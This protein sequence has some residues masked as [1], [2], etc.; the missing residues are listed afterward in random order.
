MATFDSS[1]NI[2]VDQ[3]AELAKKGTTLS[4]AQEELK[5]QNERDFYSNV[6]SDVDPDKIIVDPDAVDAVV[7]PSL[8]TVVDTKFD[9]NQAITNIDERYKDLQERIDDPRPFL[10]SGFQEGDFQLQKE[11]QNEIIAAKLKYAESKVGAPVNNHNE[12][13]FWISTL[14]QRY[15]TP[16]GKANAFEY[17]YPDGDMMEVPIV[18]TDGKK[19]V[20]TVYKKNQEEDYGLLYPFGRDVNEFG[21]VGAELLS[22][23]TLGASFAFLADPTKNPALAAGVGD[24][25]GIKVDKLINWGIGKAL[26]FE[27]GEGEFSK[28]DKLTDKGLLEWANELMPVQ[29]GADKGF[30]GVGIDED[31]FPAFLTTAFTKG[32]GVTTNMLS[33]ASRPGMVPIS[34]KVIDIAEELDLPPHI[35][36]QLA[37]NPLIHKTF[38]RA[39][40]I[41][42]FGNKKIFPQQA[43]LFSKLKAFGVSMKADTDKITKSINAQ[44]KNGDFGKKGT[45]DAIAE[46]NQALNKALK[47]ASDAQSITWKDWADLI[48]IQTN[49]LSQAMKPYKITDA[50]GK[51]RLITP[52]EGYIGLKQAFEEWDEVIT[53]GIDKTRAGVINNSAGVSYTIGGRDSLKGLINELETGTGAFRGSGASNVGGVGTNKFFNDAGELITTKVA[54][55]L[56]KKSN[57]PLI[58]LV[59][60]IK[61][62]DDVII[63]PKTNT[64]NLGAI[65]GQSSQWDAFSQLEVLRSKAF[66]LMSND[67]AAVREAARK[68]HQ[69]IVNIM[70][71]NTGKFKNGGSKKYNNSMSVHLENLKSYESVVGL[72]DMQTAIGNKISPD[73]FASKYFQPGSSYNLTLLKEALEPDNINWTAFEKSFKASLIRNPKEIKRTIQ[74]WQQKD[75][76]GLSTLLKPNEIDDLLKLSETANAMENSIVQKAFQN[77]SDNTLA[78]TQELV[79]SLLKQ[80]EGKNIG[81]ALV[82]Q[83]FIK[84]SGG[85]DGKVMNNVRSGMIEDILNKSSILDPKTNTLVI[86]PR[87]LMSEFKK[88]GESEHLKMFFTKDQL[89]TLGKFELYT[90]VLGASSDLGGQLAAAELGSEA[91]KSILDPKKGL[92]FLKTYFSYNV[93]AHLLGRDVTPKM[94]QKMIP[95]GFNSSI[96]YTAIRSAFGSIISEYMNNDFEVQREL[97]TGVDV[98]DAVVSGRENYLENF[99]SNLNSPFSKTTSQ[100]EMGQELQRIEEDKN[101]ALESSSLG[102]ANMGFRSISMN[103]GANTAERGKQLFKD[104]IT[105]AAQ[106]G[107]MNTRTAFQRVA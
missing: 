48:T 35:V 27:G 11:R 29:F 30:F 53:K 31:V 38:F 54:V 57:N 100:I 33:G 96:K 23:R 74:A 28:V 59:N 64:P 80:A 78:N 87:L 17:F 43:E 63:N 41:T 44:Y 22:A 21:V 95:N 77:Q 7:T 16:E 45:M 49:K 47:E 32:I 13:G 85:M 37:I 26:G 3:T 75:P 2:A 98:P 15:K 8:D 14:L 36:A 62:L 92:G 5:K 40:D 55:D 18:G 60:D 93:V 9:F 71:D 102:N 61:A 67:D 79:T 104:D 6:R 106:G 39:S 65:R 20:I 97:E 99:P 82:I 101:R 10:L 25:M 91:V 56:T 1:K 52:E 42:G 103:D 86:K 84:G 72:K 76:D 73:Q 34:Q 19:K 46:K 51:T 66:T 94:L 24:Y 50:N 12:L 68:I 4:T 105:F 81:D 90:N 70:D 107:I 89:A 58:E 69:K 83:N 88:L